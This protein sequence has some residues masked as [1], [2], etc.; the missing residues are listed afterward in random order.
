MFPV[1]TTKF[2]RGCW[3]LHE[4]SS[5][6]GLHARKKSEEGAVDLLQLA[7]QLHVALLPRAA[8]TADLPHLRA[9][10]QCHT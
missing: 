7:A 10:A 8:C 3:S 1:K 4:G 2:K 6:R 9:C 5:S